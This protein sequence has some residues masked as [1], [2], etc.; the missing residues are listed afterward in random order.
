MDANTS[1]FLLISIALTLG[2]KHGFDLDHLATIDAIAGVVRDNRFLS[3]MVGIFFSL[4]HGIVVVFV[5]LIIGSGLM[6]SHIP[7]WLNGFGRWISV[8]FLLLFGGINLV[9]VFRN[10]SHQTTPIGIKSFLATK[11]RI[12]KYNAWVIMSI[13]ALFACSFDTFSQIALFS[14]SGSLFSGWALP[15]I[16]G[17]SFTAG[18]MLSDGLNGLLVAALIQRSD[19]MS[20]SISRTLGLTISMFSLGIGFMGLFDIL[21]TLINRGLW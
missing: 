18:M 20:T 3:K 4:G 1:T 15:G 11:L 16:L 19:G 13:G 14:I 8:V 21:R 9:S 12:K 7:E 2:I 17:L 5:S 10:P 6:E